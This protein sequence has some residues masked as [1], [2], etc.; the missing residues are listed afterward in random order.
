VSV[1]VRSSDADDAR[2][3]WDAARVSVDD[4]V[5]V[6]TFGVEAYESEGLGQVALLVDSTYV[7]VGAIAYGNGA[8]SLE[9]ARE[10]TEVVV[11]RL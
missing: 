9:L 2:S 10:L 11:P 1:L 5:D 3:A 6:D 4:A 8:S 7:I